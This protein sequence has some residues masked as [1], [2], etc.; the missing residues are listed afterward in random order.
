SGTA[1]P[2]PIGLTWLARAH[3]AC[4]KPTEA[5]NFILK[6]LDATNETNQRWE[7]AEIYRTAGE[8]ALSPPHPNPEAAEVSFQQSLS[9][10]RRQS[11]KSPELRASISLARLWCDQGRQE[12]ARELLA[13]IYG[14]FTEGFD[15][16]DLKD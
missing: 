7:E 9:V 10:A 14:W 16:P 11:A 6:A 2:I 3:A 15:L 8:I 4:R 5:Q 13:P 1:F 12:N